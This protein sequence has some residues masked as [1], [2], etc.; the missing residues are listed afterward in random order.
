[1][2]AVGLDLRARRTLSRRKR[3]G[4]AGRRTGRETPWAIGSAV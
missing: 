1:M 4:G 2:K 3:R